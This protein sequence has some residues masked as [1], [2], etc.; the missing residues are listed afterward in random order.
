MNN[1]D[2]YNKVRKVPETAKKPIEAGRQKGKTDINP[3]WRLKTLTEQFGPCGFGW[4]IEIK[5]MWLEKGANEEIAAFVEI[6]LYIKL[7]GVDG[8]WGEA[9]PGIGG[10]LF[11]AKEKSGLYTDDDAYKKAYTDA[12]SVACKALGV[13]ADVYYEKDSTKYDARQSGTE[14]TQ[15]GAQRPPIQQ[16]YDNTPP[17]R[18]QNNVTYTPPPGE[19]ATDNAEPKQGI[20][21]Q[22][23]LHLIN[24]TSLTIERVNAWIEKVFGKAVPIDSL[25]PNNFNLLYDKLEK[26]VK[27]ETGNG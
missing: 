7:D 18:Q 3:M 21:T 6:A 27:K 17:A 8:A 11:I 22:T 9:I 26:Q 13:A 15:G 12:I 10:S 2:L 25:S 1:L 14:Q 20:Q 16:A 5:R 19:P 23:I 4:K 24:G